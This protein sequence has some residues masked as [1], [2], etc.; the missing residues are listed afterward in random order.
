MVY[1]EGDVQE[2]LNVVAGTLWSLRA[3]SDAV[4]HICMRIFGEFLLW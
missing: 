2:R 1:F 4:R 3:N